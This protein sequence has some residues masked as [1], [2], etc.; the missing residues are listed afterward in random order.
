[1][2]NGAPVVDSHS[3][4]V[5]CARMVPASAP[6]SAPALAPAS[7]PKSV[8]MQ[9]G[10]AK[11]AANVQRPAVQGVPLQQ[12]ASVPQDAVAPS[13]TSGPVFNV[14]RDNHNHYNTNI[15]YHKHV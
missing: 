7:A 6:A 14:A 8:N 5:A 12:H 4:S 1:M 10:V 13:T 15:H 11:A 2:A 3:G 9:S